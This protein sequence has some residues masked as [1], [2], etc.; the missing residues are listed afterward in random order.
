MVRLT[1]NEKNTLFSH[2][3][4]ES[5]GPHEGAGSQQLGE[6]GKKK[7]LRS[8]WMEVFS[9]AVGDNAK[10][11]HVCP[12]YQNIGLPASPLCRPE[13]C[14]WY[15]CGPGP[16][17]LASWELTGRKAQT[18][19][20]L[21]QACERIKRGWEWGEKRHNEK[22]NVNIL[23]LIIKFCSMHL[24][25]IYY[26]EPRQLEKM[27]CCFRCKVC[28][29]SYFTDFPD[30]FLCITNL[31]AKYKYFSINLSDRWFEQYFTS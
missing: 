27:K 7:E 25:I 18:E 26:K 12:H 20:R 30:G 2:Q 5:K 31:Q 28:R 13:T 14:W 15:G 9:R 19:R 22:K 17:W 24:I 8:D 21:E 11:I 10:Y 29:N 1:I 6:R 4:A 3:T 23:N 16:G